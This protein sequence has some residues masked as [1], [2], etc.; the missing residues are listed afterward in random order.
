MKSIA[1]RVGLSVQGVSGY[2]REMTAEGLIH[3]EGGAYVATVSGVAHL[4]EQFK[5][6]QAFVEQSSHAMRLL[7]SCAAIAGADIAPGQQVGL[8]ME[9][10]T[11]VA[12]PDRPSASRGKA[13]HGGQ[14]G[15]DIAVVELE[16]IVDHRLGRIRLL[17]LPGSR[18]GGS[19]AVDRAS[20]RRFLARQTPD[21]VGVTDPVATV[22]AKQMDIAIDLEYAAV[23]AALDAAQRG[24]DVLLLASEDTASE[25]VS[26]LEAGNE[27]REEKISYEVFSLPPRGGDNGDEK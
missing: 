1:D 15:T 4:H 16:G 20:A 2:L 25:A 21:L 10:G 8:F 19:G 17:R 3:R 22:V 23:S 14:R 12:Y 9:G 24:L 6:L 7:D 26:H 27:G 13:L 18:E 11:L 5:H